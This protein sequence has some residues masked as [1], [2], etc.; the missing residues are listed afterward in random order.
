MQETPEG[1]LDEFLELV[2]LA[3]AERAEGDDARAITLM[4][5]HSAKGL[6]FERVYLTGMEERVFPHARVLDDPVQLEEERRLAYVALTR[7]KRHLTLTTAARRMIF[8]QTQVGQTSR[9][10][11]DLPRESTDQVG[12]QDSWSPSTGRRAAAAPRRKTEQW[13]DDIVYD[14]DPGI[15]EDI[16]EPGDG[17]RRAALRGHDR[18][19]ATFGDAEVLG[20]SGSG[21]K[22]KLQLRLSNREVK[23]LMARFVEPL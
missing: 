20:W 9:F 10:V 13:Q 8:G 21:A 16:G 3:G 17:G 4:T 11:L 23:T 5:I 12:R 7:A 14:A 15:D 2:S 6:E 22:L 19:D 1:G 18:T